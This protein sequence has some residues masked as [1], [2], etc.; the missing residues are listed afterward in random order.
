MRPVRAAEGAGAGGGGTWSGGTALALGG[1]NCRAPGRRPAPGPARVVA[2]AVPRPGPA[3]SRHRRSRRPAGAMP[4]FRCTGPCGAAPRPWPQGKLG[5]TLFA[6]QRC[7]TGG[8]RP[9]IEAG[10]RGDQGVRALGLPPLHRHLGLD[11]VDLLERHG[12]VVRLG[13]QAALEERRTHALGA[14]ARTFAAA[15]LAQ[16]VEFALAHEVVA[17]L[18]LDHLLERGLAVLA[19]AVGRAR[20][21]VRP[22]RGR[23]AHELHHLGQEAAVGIVLGHEDSASIREEMRGAGEG[24]QSPNIF[25][26]SSRR[27]CASSDR[28]AVGRAI[29]RPTP[30]GSPVSSQ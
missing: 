8:V 24:H 6:V 27:C 5:R 17:P 15:D 19:L 18:A 7:A 4:R 25:C 16:H 14:L 23:V 30:I 9:R 10:P 22:A 3:G 28:L 13:R 1:C 2:C 11:L 29:R 12:P 21:Q 20:V 26:L